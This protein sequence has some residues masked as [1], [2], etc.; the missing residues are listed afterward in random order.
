MLGSHSMATIGSI[1]E[2]IRLACI[3]DALTLRRM[4][5]SFGRDVSVLDQLGEPDRFGLH[6]GPEL[7][8]RARSGLCPESQESLLHLRSV[9]D[10][11][12]LL[13]QTL[14]DRGRRFGWGE[15]GIDGYEFISRKARC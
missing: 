10:S 8:R 4:L 11:H 9:E 1:Q 14:N 5:L 15:H 12:K 7:F 13:V 3:P 6:E 2:T